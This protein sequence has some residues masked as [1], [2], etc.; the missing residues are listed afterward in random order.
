MMIIYNIFNFYVP[1]NIPLTTTVVT[2]SK[3]I[4]VNILLRKDDSRIPRA[5]NTINKSNNFEHLESI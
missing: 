4:N 5:I 1:M 2:V 3:L